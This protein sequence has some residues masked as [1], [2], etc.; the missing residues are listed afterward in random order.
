[1]HDWYTRSY[2]VRMLEEYD[3]I[4]A[5]HP[6]LLDVGIEC[7]LGWYPIVEAYL[8]EVARLLAEHPGATYDLRQVKEKFGGLR[9]YADRSDDIT[10]AVQAAYDRA[11]RESERTCD[12]CG[13][14][15][16][17]RKIPPGQWATRCDEHADG[18]ELVPPVTWK[19]V[20]YGRDSGG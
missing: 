13:Q 19:E 10:D 7:Q 16:A 18:G 3:R 15:G 14:P 17:M 20:D 2:S 11:A 5:K 9:L 6:T 1:M 12:V 4:Q 8:D